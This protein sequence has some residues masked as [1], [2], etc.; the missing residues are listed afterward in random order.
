MKESI[1]GFTSDIIKADHKCYWVG[2][3]DGYLFCSCGLTKSIDTII[4]K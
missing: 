4:I 2:H 3:K 1:K